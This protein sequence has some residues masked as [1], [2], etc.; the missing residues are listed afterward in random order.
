[1]SAWGFGEE[2]GGGELTPNSQMKMV[3]VLVV[4]LS[5]LRV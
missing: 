1:M 2:G 3:G 5:H 4:S